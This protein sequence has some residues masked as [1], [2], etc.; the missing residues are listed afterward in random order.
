MGKDYKISSRPPEHSLYAEEFRFTLKHPEGLPT[1]TSYFIYSEASKRHSFVREKLDLSDYDNYPLDV[2]VLDDN[3]SS[4]N[5]SKIYFINR[6]NMG[7]MISLDDH[8]ALHCCKGKMKF[9]LCAFNVT[10]PGRKTSRALFFMNAFK[11]R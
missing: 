2:V 4:P 1:E 7:P 9:S 8:S 10:E 6:D 11:E 5:C 3:R